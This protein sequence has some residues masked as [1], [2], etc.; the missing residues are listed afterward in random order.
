MN[1]WPTPLGALRRGLLAGA[2]GTAAMTAA[3]TAYYRA[4]GEEPSSTPAEVGKRIIRGVFHRS[5]DEDKTGLL[6]NLM[7][8]S[9]GSGWGIGYGLAQGTVRGRAVPS[10]LMF[11]AA[12][13]GASLIHLPVMKL[14][15]PVWNYPP[16]QLASD[17]GFHLVYGATVGVAYAALGG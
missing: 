14:A 13:W 10:G 1:A 8:W 15:P 12:V 4:R 11:G 5:V 17:A 7:H 9:Y 2:A 16:A 6:N 3:Q